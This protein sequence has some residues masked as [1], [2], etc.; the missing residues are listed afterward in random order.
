MS[1][2]VSKNKEENDGKEHKFWNTQ[3]MLLEDSVETPEGPLKEVVHD[4]VRVEPLTLPEN[5]EWKEVDLQDPSILRQLY[6][7]L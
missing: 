4:E 6:E 5:F 3:P 7:L 2:R 1:K